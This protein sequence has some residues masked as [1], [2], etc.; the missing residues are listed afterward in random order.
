MQKQR[1]VNFPGEEKFKGAAGR[2]EGIPPIIYGQGTEV[3]ELNRINYFKDK[4]VLVMG[5]GSQVR[6]GVCR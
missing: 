1:E 2:P 6:N 3:D 5:M 4:T